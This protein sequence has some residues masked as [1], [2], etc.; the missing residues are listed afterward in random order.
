MLDPDKADAIARRGRRGRPRRLG[1]RVPD[2]RVPDRLGHVVE[3]ERQR[4]A[5]HA[6]RRAARRAGAPERRRQRPAV[7]QRPVPVGDPRRR[8]RARSSSTSSRRS[9]HLA[10]ALDGEGRRVRRRRE[11]RPH[12]PDGRHAGDARPGV[13]RVRRAGALRR[14]AAAAPCC[15]A[16]AELPLGGTAVGT[17]IN[18]PGRASPRRSS[19]WLAADTGPAADR[20]ARPLRGAGRARRAG[21]AVRRAAHDR[22]R[23]EQDQPTTSAGW[24]RARAPA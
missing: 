10:A 11:V 16:S 2:R 6:R 4:G 14:R 8:D 15:P 13:R 5:R 7:V 23:P 21:R 19:R 18:A 12:P 22:G 9:T 1:R 20:G 24:A 17:G 3:H